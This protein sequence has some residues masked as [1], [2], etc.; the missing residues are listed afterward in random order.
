VYLLYSVLL[1]VA[2]AVSA[3]FYLWKGRGTGRYLGTLGDRLGGAADRLPAP[4][5]PAIWIH[6]VSVGEAMAARALVAP[7]KARLP[8][9]RVFLSTTTATGQAIARE[10]AGADGVFY[11]PFDFRRSVR[12]TLDRLRPALLVLV[13]TEIWPNLIHEAKLRGARV[14]MVN[15]RISPRSFPRYQRVRALLSRVLAEVD[16]F[17]M[18]AEAHRSRLVAMG[19]PAQRVRVSGNLKYDSLAP[20]DP[21]PA[22]RRALGQDG[23]APPPLLVAG[24]TMDGEEEAVLAAFAAVRR[25]HPQ[26]RLV[27]APRRPERFA[28]AAEQAA[29]SGMRVARRTALPADGWRDGDVLVL[30]T[31]GE[32]AQVYALAAVVFVGGSLVPRG[33]HNVLEPAVAGK[34]I[35]VGPH[36]EN[37]QEIAAAFLAEG[38]LVQ[39]RDAAGLTG[40][41]VAL[42]D[43]AARRAELGRRAREA[44]ERDRGALE[45]TVSALAALVS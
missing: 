3:P 15:G 21:P 33:G 36:M 19:A 14:A 13:E 37:F 26:A 6:A 29:A 25:G 38:A 9:H 44:V 43:D 23:P 10:A 40:A 1:A 27:L 11:A 39:V 45:R 22:L 20:P 31:V 8:G 7:L 17:L 28:A 24:S 35:V 30:D 12:R 5:G 41:L 4:D 32:L 18:Q 42:F 16:L 2:F 34:P